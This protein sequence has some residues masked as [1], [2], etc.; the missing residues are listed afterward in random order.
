MALAAR[1]HHAA[2]TFSQVTPC[3]H[4]LKATK[5]SAVQIHRRLRADEH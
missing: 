5:G 1:G 2:D 4:M 3:G